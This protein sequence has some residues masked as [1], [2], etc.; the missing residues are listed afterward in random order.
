MAI[1][2]FT[3]K[4][5]EDAARL[6]LLDTDENA[7]RFEPKEIHAAMVD[8][9]ERIRLERP[10][11]RYVGGILVD[12][13]FIQISDGG[14][15]DTSTIV[16]SPPANY[17]VTTDVEVFRNRHV[18]MERRWLPAVVNYVV[19]RMYLKDDPDTTNANLAQKY[20]ELYVNALGG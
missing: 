8:A 9:L 20:L 1:K 15:I 19:H 2:R 13:R 5:A 10:A 3:V 14:Q 4:E 16:D 6:L 11:S 17:A 12:L 18:D 7:Y